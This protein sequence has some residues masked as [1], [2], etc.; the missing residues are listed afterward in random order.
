MMVRAS[1]QMNLVSASRELTAHEPNEFVGFCKR[2][3]EPTAA[4][5]GVNQCRRVYEEEEKKMEKLKKLK[6][7][8][9]SLLKLST[10]FSSTSTGIVYNA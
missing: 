4:C 9:F 8:N 1:R 7:S 5:C 3:P 2:A 10:I 6:C